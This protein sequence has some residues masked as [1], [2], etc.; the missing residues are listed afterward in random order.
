MARMAFMEAVADGRDQDV[1]VPC[2]GRGQLRR[3]SSS[4]LREDTGMEMSRDEH[5]RGRVLGM[6]RQR[7][8][9]HDLRT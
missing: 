8:S 1:V 3:W 9:H 2:K 5:M 4:D 6:D 7:L